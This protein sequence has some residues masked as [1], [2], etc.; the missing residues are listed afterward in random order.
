[1]PE[2]P[3]ADF[4]EEMAKADLLCDQFGTSYPGM[5]TTDAYALGRPVMANL[6]N[7][8]FSSVFSK[9]LPGFDV[10]TSSEITKCLLKVENDRSLLVQMGHE[11]RTYAETYLSPKSM[12]KRLLQKILQ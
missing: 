1:L 11:S 12:A 2:M 4:Y 10:K 9:P 8:V 5:V 7:E 3:L 6:R